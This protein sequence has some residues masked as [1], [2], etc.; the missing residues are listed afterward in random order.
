MRKLTSREA[1]HKGLFLNLNDRHHHSMYL[2]RTN[3]V[4]AL[5]GP[6]CSKHFPSINP[7]STHWEVGAMIILCFID[8]A[9]EVQRG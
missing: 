2:A 4:G 5:Q 7:F 3:R 1:E 6:R 9:M 8:E